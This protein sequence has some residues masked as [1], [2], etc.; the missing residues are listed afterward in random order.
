VD[1]R[2]MGGGFPEVFAA[3]LEA[4]STLRA[5]I[6]GAIDAGLPV[7]AECGGL[8][9][10]ARTLTYKGQTHRMVGAIPGDV[11]MHER[12]VGRGYVNLEETTDFPWPPAS[13]I[14]TNVRAH[15]YH[16]SSIENLP[17]DLRYAY[18]VKRGHGADGRRDGI[19]VHNVLASYAHL[20]SSGSNPW[21][22]RFVDFVRHADYRLRRQDNIVYLSPPRG[23]EA[24]VN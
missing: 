11:V 21:A 10:L 14:G 12:P 6:R 17:A 23:R 24:I 22:A 16:Y 5:R 20:R 13:T 2:F 3:D 4:N 8:M 18:T 9:Y 19:V 15:E 7:Y 1:G